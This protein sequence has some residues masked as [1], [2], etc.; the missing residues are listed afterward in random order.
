MRIFF[1]TREP[2]V[3]QLLADKFAGIDTEIKIFPIITKLFQSIFDVGITPDILFLDFL[4]FQSDIFDFYGLLKKHDK[5]F[6]VVYYN[7]PFPIPTKRKFFWSFNLQKTGYFSDLSRIDPLLE[8]MEKALLDSKIYPYV[9]VI[10][11][12]VPYKSANLRYIEPLHESEIEFYKDRFDNVITES[13]CANSR[14][15][16]TST[17]VE[18]TSLNSADKQFT[19]TF[20]SR[21]HMSHKIKLLFTYLYSKR[22]LHVTV[23][24]LKSIFGHEK[25]QSSNALRLAI[26]RLRSILEQDIETNME[27]LNYDYGYSLIE[28]E[29]N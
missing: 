26:Y 8:I 2:D 27:I 19:D 3:C 24:E 18:F 9:S 28:K 25:K 21:N 11:Q 17:P 22:N 20:Q 29:K 15:D 12:P 1:L 6:P 4:Y 14:I 16:K 23:D 5:M 10:Q 13:L 7:H